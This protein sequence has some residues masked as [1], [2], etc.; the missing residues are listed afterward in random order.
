V[1]S[2]VV[3]ID[4]PAAAGK[5]TTAREVARRLGWLYL[6]SGA[7]YRALAVRAARRGI[8]PEDAEAIRA[9]LLATDLDVVPTPDGTR[10]LLDGEDVTS[11]IRGPVVTDL[12]SRLA[13]L[14]AV[15]ERVLVVARRVASKHSVVAEGRDMGTVAF[16]DARVKIY[17]DASIDER[18]RR[19][20]HELEARG[21]KAALD[22]VRMDLERRDR[23]DR[24]R[25]VAPL[26][27]APDSLV[28]DTTSLS[29]AEQV[30]RVL[31]IVRARHPEIGT[32]QPG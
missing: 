30:E 12:S 22:E 21:T 6:D 10:V 9:S 3:T 11:E 31:E 1:N 15:R 7:L 20:A 18:A 8:S 29:A 24:E 27:L 32:A 17:L 23:R 13:A 2:L 16:P 19:R 4:G 5:S 25:A 14:S 28:L 26:T